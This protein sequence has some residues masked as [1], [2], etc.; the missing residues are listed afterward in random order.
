MIEKRINH[1]FWCI[2]PNSG[3]T[4]GLIG[5]DWTTWDEAKYGLLKPALWQDKGKFIG[6]DHQ[7]KLGS[8]GMSLNEYFNLTPTDP[9]DPTDPTNP[10]EPIVLPG[11]VN[12]DKVVNAMDYAILKKYLLNGSSVTINQAN[13]D[14]NGDSKVNAIDFAKLKLLLLSK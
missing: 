9:T 6:L 7:V 4:G 11:D 5:Y 1:T 3:D 14:L 2:N 13:S 8:N 12:G 10:T